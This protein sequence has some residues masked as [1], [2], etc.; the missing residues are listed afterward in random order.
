M[1][2]FR[3]HKRALKSINHHRNQA[4][5]LKAKVKAQAKNLVQAVIRFSS[6]KNRDMEK[7]LRT[8]QKSFHTSPDKMV[9]ILTSLLML[10]KNL[11][12]NQI[13]YLKI[14][15]KMNQM[16]CLERNL[17]MNQMNCLERYLKMNQ[18]KILSRKNKKLLYKI[19]K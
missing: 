8:L 18:L 2:I 1:K 10:K 13:N 16:N 19:Q 7:D 15:H 6:R 12:Q 5:H 17:K 3:N 9:G 14:N 4:A 11:N